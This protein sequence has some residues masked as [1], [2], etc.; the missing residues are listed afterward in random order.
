[1]VLTAEYVLD[2][3]EQIGDR[4]ADLAD[5]RAAIRSR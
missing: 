5:T 4:F 1:L 3:V 2:R